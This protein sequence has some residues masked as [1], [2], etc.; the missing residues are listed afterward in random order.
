MAQQ[1]TD[2]NLLQVRIVSP[3]Q[4]IFQGPA[5]SVS[6]RNQ[7]GNFDILPLHANF[8]TLVEDY[9]I[10]LRLAGGQKKTFS[11]KLAII[12]LVNNK[13][14]IYTDIQLQG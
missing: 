11:F 10:T 2:P 1:N 13:V 14:N 6:S 9:P 3:K 4:D 12:Y 7:A 8:V 5:L